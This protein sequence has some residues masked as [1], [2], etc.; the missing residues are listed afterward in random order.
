VLLYA[1]LGSG[2]V[3]ILPVGPKHAREPSIHRFVFA[4]QKP[5]FQQALRDTL[6]TVVRLYEA[7]TFPLRVTDGCRWCEYRAACRKEQPP[8]VEREARAT[9]VAAFRGLDERTAPR[10]PRAGGD[11]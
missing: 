2:V 3:E 6:R 8:T 11:R 7:G 4:D 5:E 10:A 9:D 1:L